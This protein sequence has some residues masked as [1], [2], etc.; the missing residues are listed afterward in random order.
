[1][2]VLLWSWYGNQKELDTLKELGYE[3]GQQ[4]TGEEEIFSLAELA[5]KKG[6]SVAFIPNSDIITMGFSAHAGFGAR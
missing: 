2:T 1:M 3:H 6:L 4:V 5:I